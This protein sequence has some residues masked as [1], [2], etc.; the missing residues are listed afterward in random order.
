[1]PPTVIDLEPK[2]IPAAA[3]VLAAAFR[4]DPL[5]R[6]IYADF[7]RYDRAAPWMFGTWTAWAIR[8]GRAWGT[9]G[10]EAV[11]LRRPPG[12][13]QMSLWSMVR[14]GMLPAPVR[15][16]WAAFNRLE[17]FVAAAER[18]HNEIMGDRPHWYCQNVATAPAE[19]GKG[20]GAAVMGHTFAL[21]DADHLPCYIE[22]ETERAMA[23]HRHFGYELQRRVEV[24]GTDFHFFVMVRPPGPT[25]VPAGVRVTGARAGDGGR[26]TGE[27]G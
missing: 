21:A 20:F 25:T 9:P 5:F 24:P 10:L 17:R 4:D 14:A 18:A 16:G 6:Y 22:T 27:S 19:Q 1:M 2:H 23:V 3:Q 7:D 11:A 8:Y 15:M 26:V 12:T 13:Y